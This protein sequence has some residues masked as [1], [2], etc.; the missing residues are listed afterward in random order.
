MIESLFKYVNNN[1][2]IYTY[3]E[4]ERK[5]E[6]KNVPCN[7]SYNKH[8]TNIKYLCYLSYK[9]SFFRDKYILFLFIK[10]ISS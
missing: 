1:W 6:R 8:E 4:S 9:K 5:R 7:Q 2:C 3:S 10:H